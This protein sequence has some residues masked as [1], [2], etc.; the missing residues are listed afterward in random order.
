MVWFGE[1][2]K[3]TGRSG[4]G[5]SACM[6]VCVGDCFPQARCPTSCV[7]DYYTTI[8]SGLSLS[9]SPSINPSSI[10]LSRS[11]VV[12]GFGT[13]QSTQS[14]REN[15]GLNRE[16]PTDT[17][18][19]HFSLT[20]SF[21]PALSALPTLFLPKTPSLCFSTLCIMCPCL[22]LHMYLCHTRFL[23]LSCSPIT[24]LRLI[25]HPKGHRV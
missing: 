7:S 1:G 11:L 18:I 3:K 12:K 10:H 24:A 2:K 14:C 9:V 4:A 13:E 19:T 23:S 20:V 5:L 15:A 17:T 6:H 8:I 16:V 25:L 21:H 22:P